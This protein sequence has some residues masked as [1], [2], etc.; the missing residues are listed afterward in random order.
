[1]PWFAIFCSNWPSRAPTADRAGARQFPD[2]TLD[3]VIVERE[4]LPPDARQCA[5]LIQRDLVEALSNCCS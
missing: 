1:M 3:S 2:A 5:R 4:R